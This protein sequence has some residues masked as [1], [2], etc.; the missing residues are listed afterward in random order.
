MFRQEVGSDVPYG[1]NNRLAA[2]R[3]LRVWVWSQPPENGAKQAKKT[4]CLRARRDAE[5][6]RYFRC[7]DLS[8]LLQGRTDFG[9]ALL[10]QL[11]L[12]QPRRLGAL[13]RSGKGNADILG[14]NSRAPLI[15]MVS[16]PGL[17][18]RNSVPQP[19][20]RP[21]VTPEPP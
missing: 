6:F 12:W 2:P 9:F 5:H 10:W 13:H 15:V 18:R 4:C 19:K 8:P 20:K 1:W 14:K 7:L 17:D 21:R 3:S 11:L 16:C